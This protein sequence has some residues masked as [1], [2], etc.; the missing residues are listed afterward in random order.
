MLL[1][2]AAPVAAQTTLVSNHGQ[3]VNTN[4]LSTNGHVQVQG[5]RT[6]SHYE[7]YTLSAIEAVLNNTWSGTAQRDTVRAELW[8][9][10]SS[11]T[12]DAK[13]ADLTVPGTFATPLSFAAPAGT[14][15]TPETSYFFV[16]YTTGTYDV[17][18]GRVTTNNEDSGGAAGWAIWDTR[19]PKQSQTPAGS[20]SWL[21]GHTDPL[22]ITVKGSPIQPT[23]VPAAPAN[24]S[25]AVDTMALSLSWTAPVGTLTGYDV[26][27]T[28]AAASGG[29]PLSDGAPASGS[30][31]ALGVGGGDAHRHD[32]LADDFRPDQQHP[33]PRAGARG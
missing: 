3:T 1:L 6:G 26:H 23:A 16:V 9:N 20:Q 17:G 22:R 27:Y 15:L 12:P 13:L 24:L 21:T 18:L 29:N 28:S 5:F 31:P 14:T 32:G 33:I 30:D 10:S 4:H 11:N 2:A 19:T 25:V 8:S 7:G